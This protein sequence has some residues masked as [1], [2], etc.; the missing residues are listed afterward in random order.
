[1]KWKEMSHKLKQVLELKSPPVGVKIRKG[2]KASL[3]IAELDRELY[4]CLV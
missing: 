2:K 4:Y 1:M 3:G